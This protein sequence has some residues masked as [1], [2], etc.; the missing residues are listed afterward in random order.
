MTQLK[1][2]LKSSSRIFFHRAY[3][4]PVDLLTLI[5]IRSA[6]P[7]AKSGKLPAIALSK[8]TLN[9]EGKDNNAQEQVERSLLT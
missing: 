5:E 3:D 9:P 8:K 7:H 6:Q 4:L 2:V 1:K